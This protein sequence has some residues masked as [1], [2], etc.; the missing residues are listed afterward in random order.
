M[1]SETLIIGTIAL[2][3]GAGIA[4]IFKKQIKKIL[5]R[6]QKEMDEIV[7]DP[8]LLVEKLNKNGKM[9]DSGEE[10]KYSVVEEG[11]VRKV[12]LERTKVKPEPP[13]QPQTAKKKVS[14]KKKVVK[15]NVRPK[16]KK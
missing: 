9:V 10:L 16:S 14:K 7:N 5:N 1:G 2:L 15:K 3:L 6:K 4:H 11:G 8:D 13:L 12:S